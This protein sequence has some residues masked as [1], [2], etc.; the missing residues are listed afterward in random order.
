[1]FVSGQ[2]ERRNASSMTAPVAACIYTYASYVVRTINNPDDVVVLLLMTHEPAPARPSNQPADVKGSES[3]S[4]QQE[5]AHPTV[6]TLSSTTW[7]AS[8][9]VQAEFPQF[10]RARA[11]PGRLSNVL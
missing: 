9:P 3:E 11:P 8:G 7:P 4:N 5:T 10:S 2:T 6:T 1:M